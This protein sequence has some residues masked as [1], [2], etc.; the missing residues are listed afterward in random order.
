MGGQNRYLRVYLCNVSFI[1]LF[2]CRGVT[3]QRKS[4]KG[5]PRIG[6]MPFSFYS[7]PVSHGWRMLEFGLDFLY[8]YCNANSLAIKPSQCLVAPGRPLRRQRA[9]A[10]PYLVRSGFHGP[11]RRSRGGLAAGPVRSRPARAAFVLRRIE[12]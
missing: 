6:S 12:G 5:N 9:D 10:A 7:E 1:C 3:F 8:L 4:G 2:D 11:P